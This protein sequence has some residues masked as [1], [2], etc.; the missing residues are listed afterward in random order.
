VVPNEMKA[1]YEAMLQTG[2]SE[3]SLADYK[4]FFKAF[5]KREITDFDGIAAEVESKSTE[6]VARYLRVFL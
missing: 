2:F 5:R 1:R 6:E 3:W 4:Q